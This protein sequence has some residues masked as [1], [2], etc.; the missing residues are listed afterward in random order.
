VGNFKR[1]DIYNFSLAE[2]WRGEP[3]RQVEVGEI[4]KYL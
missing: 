2:I 1:G 4:P 3:I